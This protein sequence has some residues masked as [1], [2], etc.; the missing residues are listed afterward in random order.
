MST[1]VS[2]VC[3]LVRGWSTDSFYTDM[4]SG[5]AYVHGGSPAYGRTGSQKGL[6]I[7]SCSTNVVP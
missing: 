7:Y 3:E 2:I 1:P 5:P 6:R 4:M